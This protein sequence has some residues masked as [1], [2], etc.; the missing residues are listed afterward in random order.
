MG[1]SQ[2]SIQ[3]LNRVRPVPSLPPSKCS[4]FIDIIAEKLGNNVISTSW[5]A[6]PAFEREPVPDYKNW[7]YDVTK[8]TGRYKALFGFRSG[9][10]SKDTALEAIFSIRGVLTKEDILIKKGTRYKFFDHSSDDD[11]NLVLKE[12]FLNCL[13][14]IQAE[15]RRGNWEEVKMIIQ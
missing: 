15:G 13:Q 2:G 4:N 12:M 3:L 6:E 10:V 8:L 7:D 5:L 9:I 1:M 11:L 14:Y